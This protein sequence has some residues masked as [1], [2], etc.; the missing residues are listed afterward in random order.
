MRG[1]VFVAVTIACLLAGCAVKPLK[2]PCARDEGPALVRMAYSSL[3]GAG[4]GACGPMKPVNAGSL[5]GRA[6][7]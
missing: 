3:V 5:E 4:E 1:R 7:R 6:P 2:A